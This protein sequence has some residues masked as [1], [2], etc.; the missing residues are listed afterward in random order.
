MRGSR[1]PAPSRGSVLN[2]AKNCVE[3]AP[4]MAVWPALSIFLRVPSFNLP[5]DGLRDAPDPRQS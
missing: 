2:T 5:G 4:W 1:S 3:N